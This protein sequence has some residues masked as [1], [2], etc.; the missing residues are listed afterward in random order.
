MSDLS[1]NARYRATLERLYS[2][3]AHFDRQGPTA[4]NADLSKTQRLLS[5]LG[6]PHTRFRSV[7]IAGTNGKGSVAAMTAAIATAAG[8]EAGL[9]RV[10]LFTSPHLVDFAERIRVNGVEVAHEWVVKWVEAH[11]GLIA[12]VNPSFFELNTAMAFD[13]FAQQRVDLAVVE[14]G[15]G[16]RLDSTNVLTPLVA[17]VTSIGLD[18]TELLGDTLELIAAEKAGIFKPGV[19]AV[20]GEDRADTR[21]TFERVSA[22]VGAP[23]WWASR[24]YAIGRTGWSPYGQTVQVNRLVEPSNESP[25]SFSLTLSLLGDYQLANL[26]TVLSIRDALA[27][28]GIRIPVA[29]LEQGLAKV[30]E[31]TGLRGRMD[32]LQGSQDGPLVIA[33]IAHNP[34]ALSPVMAQVERLVAERGGDLHVVIGAS[35]D[36]DLRGLIALLPQ[37]ATYY[38][39]R[40]DNPR[41]YPAPELQALGEEVELI[42]A[43]YA[44]VALGVRAAIAFAEQNDVVLITG[45]AYVV[46]EAIGGWTLR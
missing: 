2:R 22:G 18:H 24:R 9:A 23:L 28:Q 15:L 3:L 25:A 10:G 20:V 4:Y 19:V 32:V 40:A 41:A 38:Y 46:G 29:A 21:S 33:D 45:S 7:H 5:A 39:V 44:S 16:G 43:Y 26:A 17:A 8:A 12:E 1:L 14:V 31:L 30:Q 34:A 42:G 36:K 37:S 13:Y 6:D 35:A 11:E 27:E